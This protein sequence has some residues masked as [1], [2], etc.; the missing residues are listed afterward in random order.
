MTIQPQ[1]TNSRFG[2]NVSFFFCVDEMN[3]RSKHLL[4]YRTDDIVSIDRHWRRHWGR[5]HGRFIDVGCV[6]KDF[7]I[8]QDAKVQF[9]NGRIDGIAHQ[10]LL[11]GRILLR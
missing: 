2:D 8:R 5:H 9:G 6:E 10:Q 4:T 11:G 3:A 1:R 7:L